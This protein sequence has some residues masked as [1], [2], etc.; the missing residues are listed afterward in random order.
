MDILLSLR[1]F[2]KAV[3]ER[4]DWG[5]EDLKARLLPDGVADGCEL[6]FVLNRTR[7]DKPWGDHGRAYH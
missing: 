1:T 4:A 2:G 3:S 5:R 7:K 6:N